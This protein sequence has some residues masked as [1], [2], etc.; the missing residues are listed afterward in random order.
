MPAYGVPNEQGGSND[1]SVEERWHVVNYLKNG[2]LK[3]T[4]MA[5]K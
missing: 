3:E 2:L 4:T 5:A 1:L